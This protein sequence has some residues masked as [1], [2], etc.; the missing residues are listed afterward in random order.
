MTKPMG[1]MRWALLITVAL[2]LLLAVYT[3]WPLIG[4]Y[5]IASAIE[6]RNATAF[7]ERVDFRLLR[8]SLTQQVIAEYLRLTGREAKLGPFRGVATG[9]GASLADP[10]VARFLNAETLLEL[11]TKG[12]AGDH[13]KLSSEVAPFSS[14]L[15]GDAWQV[16][17]HSA[18]RG[19]DF[20]VYLPPEKSK[21]D[22][23][24]VRLSLSGLEW[25]L[26][27]L[28]LPDALR[29]Q[30]AQEVLRQEQKSKK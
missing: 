7:S 19:T 18:Y 1:S 26:T 8:R 6:S 20:Y 25:K 5:R 30:L 10:I 17:W 27:G 14:S 23:F 2:V 28:V 22:Q 29:V 16:W 11:L 12:T 15:W 3:V 4:F 24:G 21:S 9:I 13:T